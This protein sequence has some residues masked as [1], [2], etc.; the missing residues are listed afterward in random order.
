M[1]QS[2]AVCV[3][4]A[5]S[6]FSICQECE[7]ATSSALL[8]APNWLQSS[9]VAEISE[10]LEGCPWHLPLLVDVLSQVHGSIWHPEAQI[11][12]LLCGP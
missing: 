10:L 2:K 9:C 8:V 6:P 7:V 4:R 1:A 3:S 5:S 11:M 12:K